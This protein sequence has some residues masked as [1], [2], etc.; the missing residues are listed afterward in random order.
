MLEEELDFLRNGAMAAPVSLVCGQTDVW[1]I[2][3]V[4]YKAT[5]LLL[6][7]RTTVDRDALCH[8]VLKDRFSA[9]A[10]SPEAHRVATGGGRR[11]PFP[12]KLQ[13]ETVCAISAILRN[14]SND[15]RVTLSRRVEWLARFAGYPVVQG[16]TA[17]RQAISDEL[18]PKLTAYLLCLFL[19]LRGQGGGK[20]IPEGELDE[21]IAK[22]LILEWQE[23]GARLEGVEIDPMAYAE[24]PVFS[25]M[26]RDCFR[27]FRLI[28]TSRGFCLQIRGTP[29][30]NRDP[31][32]HRTTWRWG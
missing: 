10:L 13:A 6:G 16:V 18:S 1:M 7:I 20:L 25:F 26:V 21:G 28:R 32:S 17:S 15:G 12:L 19:A 9:V 3:S 8:V 22:R 5:G 2:F 30:G 29:T 31:C 4:F 11:K 23:D 27:C 14:L 24:D